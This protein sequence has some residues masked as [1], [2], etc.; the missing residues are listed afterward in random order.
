MIKRYCSWIFPF[1]VLED[2]MRMKKKTKLLTGIAVL[3][4]CYICTNVLE[5][6]S[7]STIDQKCKA[8]IAI[9]L[10]AA[11][12]NGEVSP[13][14]Q[15]RINHGITLYNEGYVEKLIVTGGIASGNSESDAYAAKQ[16]A[17]SQGVPDADILT[18]DMST[19]TQENLENAKIIMDENGYSTAII[20]SDPL[21]M[22]RS[23][24]LAKDA[25][26][27]AYSSPTP[28]SKYISLKTQIPFLAR[29][30]FFY[31]GYKWYRIFIF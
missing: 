13:V 30:V 11:T 7:F 22:K 2:G 27:D 10:G 1:R 25:A 21:H 3:A 29:E 19:I 4:V 20:V 24:L 17:V 12:Y 8:D 16:Y 5:I 14:Y 6:C 18:E 26:I 31:I 9:I 15:E 23:M 28:T